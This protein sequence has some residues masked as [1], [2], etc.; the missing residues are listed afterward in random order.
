MK[1][2]RELTS[3]ILALVMLASISI[4]ITFAADKNIAPLGA[5]LTGLEAI[6]SQP[7]NVSLEASGDELPASYN[8]ADKGFVLPVRVQQ[9]N[10]CWAF[11]AL[12]TLETLL[13]SKG[14]NISTFAP[15]H[16]NLWGT[17]RDDGTGW[18]R[19]EYSG[20][21]SYIPL[22]Y[23]TSW[24]GAV[25]EADFPTYFGKEDYEQFSKTPDYGLTEAIF[26]NSDAERDAIK[27]LIYTYGS[28]VGNYNANINY[29]SKSDSFYCADSSFTVSQ[30]TG[31][32]VSVVGWDDD[33]AKEH[34]AY[35]ASGTPNDDGAWLIKNSWGEYSGNNGYYWIS[36]EDV[37]MFDDIFGPSYALTSYEEI[38]DN[39]KIYQN[40]IDGATYEC[41][42]FTSEYD[43]YSAI[44]YMNVF[45]F[46]EGHR[47]LSKVV[48]ET[49]SMGADYTVH[50]I[51]M[52]NG[53]PT[54]NTNLW[55]Q[56][57]QG[58]VDYTGYICVDTED[59]LLPAGK[60]AIGITID[61]ERTYLENKYKDDYTYIYNSIGVSEW[62]NSGG[63]RI[64][65]P[66][67]EYGM[68]Y[69][70]KNGTVRDVMD[71]Y[72]NTWNDY[73]GGTFVIKAI[74][75]S[76]VAEVKGH[77]ITLS[78]D[79]GVNFFLDLS[80]QTLADK[81][82]K[83]VFE[84]ASTS[85]EVPVSEGILC[86]EGY[87]FTCPVPAKDMASIVS[88]KVVTSS[89]ESEAF[90]K[91]VKE[92][93]QSMLANAEEYTNVIPLVKSMLNYGAA[94]QTYF[95]Y[96]TNSLANDTQYMTQE[97][98][99]LEKADFS[100]YSLT[101]T[102]GNGDVSYYGSSLSLKSETLINHYFRI[103]SNVDVTTISAIVEG[104]PAEL[105]KNGDMYMVTVNHIPAHN[106]YNEY[107][108]QVGDVTLIHSIA[109]YAAKAM[110]TQKTQLINVMYALNAYTKCAQEYMNL[111]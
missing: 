16:A 63:R 46:E 77:S 6:G 42:Y 31:H 15:Q 13:L 101:L 26:F 52:E 86:E 27:E 7:L 1:T 111:Q 19:N 25:Y 74:T 99:T 73:I 20:G 105:V 47:N 92:Y 40:E 3:L 79:I 107:T 29:L 22:G 76:P 32:C 21:Y 59:T 12:S 72:A 43:P 106:I 70:M 54:N 51:P 58:T 17:V 71:F 9:D 100:P 95:D 83:V 75:N 61:N 93:A 91:S 108:I 41:T 8:S 23:L 87:K 85:L 104:T 64:F 110:E 88:C 66:Q 109:S 68:S 69:Y 94:A 35:S 67:S 4:V 84:Y 65:T 38:T 80:A 39:H 102:Q 89:R 10:T 2:L 34:F 50:Y 55:T 90:T 30:L 103:S 62:L 33:Y 49:T 5:N 44:T 60:G 57:A 11:G 78:G 37:W 14:E 48:F 45:D 98:K 36:Y 53:A 97:D 18:Q 82:A 56:L 28:V 24:A 96:N 81:N